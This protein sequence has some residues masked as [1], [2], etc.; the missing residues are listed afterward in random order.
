MTEPG[1]GAEAKRGD[2][3]V[4]DR[5]RTIGRVDAVF[6]DYLLV[7]TRSLLPV[8]LYVPRDAISTDAEGRLR[9]EQDRRAAYQAWHRPLKRAPHA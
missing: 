2:R 1:A 4:G 9:V 7:R 8:D 6:A 3:L 5:G